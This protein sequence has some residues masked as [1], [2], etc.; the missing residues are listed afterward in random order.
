MKILVVEDEQP[1]AEML[2][3]ALEALGND[4]LCAYDAATATEILREQPVDAV[5]LDL[6]MPGQPGMNW[7][8][9]I[10]ETHPDLARSTL[11]IT[12]SHL[13]AETVERLARC[14]A[15]VL[16]KP[17]TLESLAEAVRAQIAR[18]PLP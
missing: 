13:D 16:A 1:V 2:C 14:G 3:K 9:S 5:T 11:V 6:C 4:C 7:L 15:G 17:F 12:G 8:E 18:P 10:A